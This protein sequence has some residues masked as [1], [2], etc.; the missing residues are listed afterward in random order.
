[1]EEIIQK[2]EAD[3]AELEERAT[4]AAEK[5]AEA[6]ASM[7]AVKQEIANNKGADSMKQKEAM[8]LK[9]LSQDM[10]ELRNKWVKE[11]N[12]K[13]ITEMNKAMAAGAS[14]T[15]KTIMDSL[16]QFF[17][18]DPSSTYAAT[19]DVFFVDASVYGQQIRKTKPEKL[20]KEA[21]KRIA[22]LVNQDE[23]KEPGSI[24]KEMIDPLKAG[25]NLPFFV[26]YKL[27]FK[28]C[29]MA[30]S[31][32][33][34]KGIE[35]SL[36][37]TNEKNKALQVQVDTYETISKNLA[38]GEQLKAEAER[39]RKEEIAVLQRK[40]ES[41]KEEIAKIK[42]VDFVKEYFASLLE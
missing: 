3:A 39:M 19:K 9:E 25:E 4:A 17:T 2:L 21:V 22:Q 37:G 8:G 6:N 42:D 15:H 26:H 31:L 10:S 23:N 36:A 30:I 16:A 12:E 14:E 40:H 32:R 38:F 27:L 24:Q 5:Q 11:A 1:M 35:K 18:A 41:L 34:M 29:Q 28:L 13:N 33:K 20:D 7:D